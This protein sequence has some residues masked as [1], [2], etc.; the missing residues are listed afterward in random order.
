[1]VKRSKLALTFFTLIKKITEM[2]LFHVAAV[3]LV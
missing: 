2:K 3:N 1:M